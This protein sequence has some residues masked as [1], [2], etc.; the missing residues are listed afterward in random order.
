MYNLNLF[1]I[2][3]RVIQLGD[4]AAKGAVNWL[5]GHF[6]RPFAFDTTDFNVQDTFTV[7]RSEFL[8]E[9]RTNKEFREALAEHDF[10]Y[11]DGLVCLN[12]P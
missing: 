4:L 8:E 10:I 9:C 1:N 2:K 7:S 5:D 12:E 3:T 6:I 11:V